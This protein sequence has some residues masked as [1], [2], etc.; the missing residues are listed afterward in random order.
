MFQDFANGISPRSIAQRL[1]DERIPGPGGKLWSSTTLRGHVKRGTGFLNNELYVG[2][3]VWNRQRYLKDPRTGRRV[4]RINPESAWITTEV[5]ELRIVD[6]ALWQA[7]K[8]RQKSIGV[9]YAAAIE[10][11]RAVRLNSTHRPK[12]L[13]SGLLFCGCCGGSY[14]LRGQ[15]RFMCSSHADNN[16]C[17]NSRTIVRGMIEAR[18]LDGLRDKLMAPEIAAEAVR[19]YVEETNRLNHQRRAAGT[20]DRAEL[21]KVLKAIGGLAEMAMDGRGTRTVADKLLELEAQED[22][23]RARLAEAP[24]DKPD[25][26]PNIAEIYRRKVERLSEA[27]NHPAERDA[28]ADAI[29]GLIERVTLTPG[30]KRG[31]L[32]ATLHGEFGA[33][34]EWVA[35]REA[36]ESRHDKT[37]SACALGVLSVSLVAGTGTTRARCTRQTHELSRVF[38]GILAGYPDRYPNHLW[39]RRREGILGRNHTALNMFARRR[40]SVVAVPFLSGNESRIAGRV[41]K[42]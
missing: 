3:L 12:S 33:I 26:H 20:V 17:S 40:L 31:V 5:P 22:A 36:Q 34:L 8:A 10:G 18:V 15:G 1:N 25:I 13:L 6:D 41:L 4:S 32:D 27:L 37:P 39:K 7:V 14:S 21:E 11:T 29:R 9:Q 30:P 2:K 23:I 42:T 28:A 19:A 38:I 35:A 16:S 24:L